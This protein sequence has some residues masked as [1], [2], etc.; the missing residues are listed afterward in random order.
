MLLKENLYFTL[1]KLL[2]AKM[3]HFSKL[4]FNFTYLASTKIYGES[5]DSR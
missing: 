2:L 5:K 3:K 1:A 4:I